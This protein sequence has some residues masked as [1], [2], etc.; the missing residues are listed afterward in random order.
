M[1]KRSSRWHTGRGRV[2]FFLLL[3]T[4]LLVLTAIQLRP[5]VEG[6]AAY[7]TKVFATK[8][9]NDAILAELAREGVEYEDMV[10]LSYNSSGD[11]TS[12][13]S[14][15]MEINRL[16]AQI[17]KAVLETLE[18]MGSASIWVPLG[19]LLGNEF[20]SGRGPM[21]EIK[22][23]PTGYVQTEIYSQFTSAGINQ[24]NHQ[25]FLGTSIQMMAAIPG[26]RIKCET[27]TSFLIAQTVIV[28][29][30]PDTYIQ[31]GESS[32]FISKLKDEIQPAG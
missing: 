2:W 10:R 3:L 21:V 5:V 9:I 32:P 1:K 4:L 12:I 17:T 22:I 18:N 30:I 16:K 28:G 20:T 7:Q 6:V 8:T 27:S 14:N 26:Y 15:M 24:T 25:I 31:L 29:N 19:T 23:Y 13:Q 11:I